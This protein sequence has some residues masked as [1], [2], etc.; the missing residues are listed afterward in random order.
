MPGLSMCAP[1]G[2]PFTSAA[3]LSLSCTSARLVAP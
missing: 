3:R 1:T 2:L